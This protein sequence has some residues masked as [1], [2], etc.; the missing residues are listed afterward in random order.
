MEG[1][2]G[3][4]GKGGNPEEDK[5]TPT[6]NPGATAEPWK[7]AEGETEGTEEVGGKRAEK[8]EAVERGKEGAC[9]CGGR[10]KPG[11]GAVAKE[12]KPGRE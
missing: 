6:P 9:G 4:E 2:D 1:A 8:E 3:Y 12:G 10:A 11:G 7:E 5:R